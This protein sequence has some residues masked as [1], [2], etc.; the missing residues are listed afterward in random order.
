M[1][2]IYRYEKKAQALILFHNS[3]LASLTD[4]SSIKKTKRI[5]E[6]STKM[7]S[8][9]LLLTLLFSL[10][11][12]LFSK[13]STATTSMDPSLFRDPLTRDPTAP[14]HTHPRILTRGAQLECKTSEDSPAVRDIYV[15]TIK[16]H[17]RK[18][19]WCTQE[20]NHCT[21]FSA[22]KSANLA[23][24]AGKGWAI[25][26]EDLAWIGKMVARYCDVDGRAGVGR[27]VPGRGGEGGC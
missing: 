25:R 3:F 8:K 22:Y 5:P 10:F 2:Q 21:T 27:V 26:C 6:K 12:L 15:A 7:Q 4:K 17:K 13:G 23:I 11:H 14:L 20:G 24:C 16:L 1:R 19:T 9:T 18:S